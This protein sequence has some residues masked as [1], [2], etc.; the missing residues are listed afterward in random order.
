MNLGDTVRDTITAFEGVV[1]SR[2]EYLNGCVRLGVQ[3][4]AMHEGKPVESQ[5]F[6]IEQLELVS[7]AAKREVEPRGGPARYE[8]PRRST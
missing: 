3:P 4:R 7:V 1:V 6:D 8:P 5:A 2:H